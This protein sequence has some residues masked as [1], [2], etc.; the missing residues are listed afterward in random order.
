[1]HWGSL[2]SA[3]LTLFQIVTLEAW[4][5]LMKSMMAVYPSAWIYFVSFVV[6]G[7]FVVI[8]LFIAVVI[9]NLHDARI[10]PQDHDLH[11]PASK[12]QLLK[13]LDETHAALQRL[14]QRLEK[15]PH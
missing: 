10:E 2:G 12:M 11:L 5:D 9:N 15:L 3:L 13:E 8:N 4:A 7:T 6:I 1:V 14:K